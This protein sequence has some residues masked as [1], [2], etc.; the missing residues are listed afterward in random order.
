MGDKTATQL[1]EDFGVRLCAARIAA[2]F[3]TRKELA[4]HIGVDQNTYTPWERG[5]SYPSAK[6]LLAL[7]EAVGVSLDWLMAGDE[8]NLS[9]ETFRKVSKAMPRAREIKSG[10]ARPS[11]LSN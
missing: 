11:N 1:L 10:R 6:T 3:S 9:V 8:R 5:R 4:D 2:G 7:R